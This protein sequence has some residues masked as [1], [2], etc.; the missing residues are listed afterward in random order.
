MAETSKALFD[1][2][3]RFLC[4]SFL[5]LHCLLRDGLATPEWCKLGFSIEELYKL[6]YRNLCSPPDL[7]VPCSRAS[8]CG[9]SHRYPTPERIM[10]NCTFLITRSH[11]I[12][13]TKEHRLPACYRTRQRI[14]ETTG[15]PLPCAAIL[16]SATQS[17]VILPELLSNPAVMENSLQCVAVLIY[18][19]RDICIGAYGDYSATLRRHLSNRCCL[20]HRQWADC[21]HLWLRP[22]QVRVNTDSMVF[23]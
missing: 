18:F 12:D 23:S 4:E 17:Y 13:P 10:D 11:G 8:L 7:E 21:S 16:L 5:F 20:M 2:V 3:G 19:T 9:G 6:T 15:L 14:S 22:N 1:L